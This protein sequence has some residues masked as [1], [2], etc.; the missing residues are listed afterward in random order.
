MSTF[1]RL[2]RRLTQLGKL[3]WK[4][5]GCEEGLSNVYETM[6]VGTEVALGWRERSVGKR[7]KQGAHWKRKW[8]T[9]YILRVR[10]DALDGFEEEGKAC[11]S[12]YKMVEGRLNK[13][14][15]KAERDKKRSALGKL[16][17]LAVQAKAIS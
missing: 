12:L 15:V 1:T 8:V 2:V 17:K 7:F 4:F 11:E 6:A 9:E 16:R 3:K 10:Y 14:A 13:E 5:L